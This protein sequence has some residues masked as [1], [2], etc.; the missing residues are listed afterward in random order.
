MQQ[1]MESQALEH[2]LEA[3]RLSP[4]NAQ[5]RSLVGVVKLHQNDIPAALAALESA[6]EVDPGNT[7]ALGNLATFYFQRQDWLLA[8][9]HFRSYCEIRSESGEALLQ[10]AACLIA[11]G[12]EQEAW[13]VLCQFLARGQPG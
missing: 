11:L 12:Q 7:N 2:A 1:G 9:R 5:M 13:H 3:E 10:Y 6:L 4:G 8:A